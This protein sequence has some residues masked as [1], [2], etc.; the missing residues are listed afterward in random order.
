MSSVELLLTRRSV[1]AKDLC[2][3]GPGPEQLNDILRAAHRV[4]DHG[5]LGPWRFVVFTGEARSRFGQ[6]L[7]DIYL[8][9]NPDCKDA[10][11]AFQRDLLLRAPLVI[12][13]IST[14]S[15]HVKIPIWEQELSAGAA[16]QNILVAAQAMG[17]GA[18]W[19]TEWYSFDTRV[20][21]MLGMDTHHKVA[22]FLYIGTKSSEPD[23]RARPSL[24]DR[25]TYWP[26]K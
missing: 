2:E 15:E 8:Q 20:H 13:V 11:L 24:E 7:A 16:C 3:P 12:G 23:D 22:G 4:P 17:Y 26:N 19:L 14:A 9:D 21:D 1:M 5:K 25:I 18:Q 10:V 6:Q